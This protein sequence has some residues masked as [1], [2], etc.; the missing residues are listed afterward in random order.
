MRGCSTEAKPDFSAFPYECSE[1]SQVDG[2]IFL[3]NL[4]LLGEIFILQELKHRYRYMKNLQSPQNSKQT[5][6]PK[7]HQETVTKI[8]PLKCL[9]RGCALFP[10]GFPL[11]FRQ[12]LFHGSGHF[13]TPSVVKDARHSLLQPRWPHAHPVPKHSY[14]GIKKGPLVVFTQPRI[15]M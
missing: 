2:T 11:S 10:S 12:A 3:L 4:E 5:K 9:L 6:Q 14:L 8:N 13:I 7:T 15:F 1:F